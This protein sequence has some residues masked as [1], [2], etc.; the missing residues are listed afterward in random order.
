[1]QSNTPK[2]ALISVERHS[3]SQTLCSTLRH[4]M[5]DHNGKC[6]AED[7]TQQSVLQMSLRGLLAD[8]EQWR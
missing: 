4:L 1:M 2:C 7:E 3:Q 5:W 8:S 6:R